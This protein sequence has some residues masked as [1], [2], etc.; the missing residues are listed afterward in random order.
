MGFSGRIWLVYFMSVTFDQCI[1]SK[2]NLK[3]CFCV[4]G[5]PTYISIFYLVRSDLYVIKLPHPSKK[6]N[7]SSETDIKIA[8]F[9][10]PEWLKSVV[11]ISCEGQSCGFYHASAYK[12]S[13]YLYYWT[14]T[15]A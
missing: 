4:I 6:E 8:F 10:M 3:I 2:W 5:K 7:K 9:G 11:V 13:L 1:S 12:T 15:S 14:V